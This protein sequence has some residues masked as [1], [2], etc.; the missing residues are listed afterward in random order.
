MRFSRLLLL[1]GLCLV[2]TGALAADEDCDAAVDAAD[3]LTRNDDGHCD[4]TKTG[5][6]GALHRALA[7]KSEVAQESGNINN[8]VL[9]SLPNAPQLLAEF[10]SAAQLQSLRFSLIQ[11][12]GQECPKGFVLESERYLPAAN[13]AMKL[14]LVYRCL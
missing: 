5:L 8:E 4:Y 14:E 11:K 2:C 6:N 3:R 1:S 13:K 9:T 10:N 12:A 7:K